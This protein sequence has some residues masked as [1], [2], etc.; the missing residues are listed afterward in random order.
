MGELRNHAKCRSG[1][2]VFRISLEARSE[3]DK[4]QPSY[5][6]LGWLEFFNLFC[7]GL[8]FCCNCTNGSLSDSYVNVSCLLLFWHNFFMETSFSVGLVTASSCGVSKHKG[9][10]R[11]G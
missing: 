7:V 9:G 3:V 8:G 6:K 4:K 11:G 2:R 10:V 1:S 5:I